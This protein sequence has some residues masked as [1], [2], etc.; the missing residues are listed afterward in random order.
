MLDISSGITPERLAEYAADPAIDIIGDISS[1]YKW[2][3]PM[4]DSDLGNDFRQNFE[5]QIPTVIVQGTWDTSTPYE[6]AIELFPY[7]KNSKLIPVK[8]GPH[9]AIRAAFAVSE[10]FRKALFK[11]AATG[12][13]SDLPDDIEIPLSKWK[14]PAKK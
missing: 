9:S 13:R 6:N 4:W 1:F 3:T 12:D 7:F 10:P 11:F 2:A 5:T 14:L 8:R